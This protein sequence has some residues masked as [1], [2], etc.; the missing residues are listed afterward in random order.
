MQH[1]MR[2]LLAAMRLLSLATAAAAAD[3]ALVTFDG[4]K[5]TTFT[6]AELNDPVM[7]GE[8]V[9]TWTQTTVGR[10]NGTIVD[11]PS[12]KA[13]GF[14]KASADGAFADASAAAGGSLVITARSA[15]AYGGYRVSVVS[16]TMAPAYACSGGGQLPLSRGCFKARFNA[17]AST[18]E[19][20][21]P[22]AA[23]SD[24]WSPATGDHTA[25]CKDEADACLTAEKLAK[26]ARVELWAEG[27]DGDVDLEVTSIV[28]RPAAVASAPPKPFDACSGPV[29]KTLKYGISG[30]TPAGV[31]V[32]VGADEMLAD[33]VCCDTRALPFAEP[34][35]LYQAPDVALFSKIDADGVTT[36]YDS[37]CGA[38]LFR[39][40]VNRSFADFKADTDE[41]GWPSFRAAEVV[42]E[43]V[44]VNAT[45]TLVASSCGTHLGTYLP[46]GKGPRWC[47]DTACIAGAPADQ[48]PATYD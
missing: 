31:P 26:I 28:A 48:V 43:H 20:V 4:A 24:K 6:F 21:V 12:L 39:A 10:M 41:H 35:F 27:V 22:F 37:V 13:P 42:E 5:G 40:P 17:T 8:S 47:I 45:T 30:R 2:L 36:F 3:I 32:A 9:G 44:R 18:S 34:Q 15:T 7:G 16:G 11:V 33:V 46:D 38:P 25:E 14:I 23:F 19:I 29:Q 1:A